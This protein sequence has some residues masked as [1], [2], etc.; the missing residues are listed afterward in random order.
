[1][2][3]PTPTQFDIIARVAACGWDTLS[4]N[5][6]RTAERSP[7]L[8]VEIDHEAGDPEHGDIRKVARLTDEGAAWYAGA[9]KK[10]LDKEADG[11]WVLSKAG[12]ADDIADWL[13]GNLTRIYIEWKNE[14]CPGTWSAYAAEAVRVKWSKR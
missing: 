10:R 3:K 12:I 4:K 7:Y 9:H 8:H 6:I 2:K 14:G 5:E 1:M 11:S 13:E